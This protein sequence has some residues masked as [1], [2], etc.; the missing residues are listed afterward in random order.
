MLVAIFTIIILQSSN[1]FAADWKQVAKNDLGTYYVDFESLKDNNG[2]IEYSDLINFFESYN[3]AYSAINKYIVDCKAEKQTW[4]SSTTHSELM[5]D[6]VII[7]QSK[8][9]QVIYPKSNTIYYFI[10]KNVCSYEK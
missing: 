6:G 9:D 8:P 1:L 3:D 5:G 7:S 4:L 10:I 2:L